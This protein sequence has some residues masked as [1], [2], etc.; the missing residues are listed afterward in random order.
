M[1]K[2]TTLCAIAVL[3][4]L[5]FGCNQADQL[6]IPSAPAAAIETPIEFSEPLRVSDG[7]R[8]QAQQIPAAP[9]GAAIQHVQLADVELEERQ[10]LTLCCPTAVMNTL[11]RILE[12]SFEAAHPRV[13]L[14]LSPDKDRNCMEHVMIGNRQAALVTSP[15]SA[16][17]KQHGLQAQ[18]LGYSIAVPVVHHSNPTRSLGR[19]AFSKVLNGEFGTWDQMQW[20]PLQ[21]QPMLSSEYL[22]WHQGDAMP[23]YSGQ[24][25]AKT[26]YLHNDAAVL[27][28][29][30]NNPG[31][32]GLVS[33]TAFAALGEKN[34]SLRPLAIGHIQASAQ[35]YQN[36]M[37]P[38]GQT[39]WLV[40]PAQPSK[41]AILL[42]EFLSQD[43][44]QRMLQS[45]LQLP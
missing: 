17:E 24:A 9:G 12:Q 14:I 22:H 41:A 23:K 20:S 21:I 7:L 8:D 27:N 40:L 32:I 37:Y 44:G 10:M 16:S 28:H 4:L 33:L 26:L 38:L 19:Q 2:N 11:G 42:R 15:L 18:V 6:E 1:G 3:P 45:R 36:E 30:Q 34:E 5:L 39:Y 29:L 43:R 31:A 13:S 35:N 25:H